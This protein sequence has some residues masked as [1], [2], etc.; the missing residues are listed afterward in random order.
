[1]EGEHAGR[2]E[3][4]QSRAEGDRDA[5]GLVHRPALSFAEARV[6]FSV[7]RTASLTRRRSR[8]ARRACAALRMARTRPSHPRW[9]AIAHPTARGKNAPRADAPRRITATVTSTR[10]SSWPSTRWSAIASPRA[11]PARAKSAIVSA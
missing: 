5:H 1:D 2:Q 10:R 9:N 7:A 11:D 3:G 4:E 8:R 6:S